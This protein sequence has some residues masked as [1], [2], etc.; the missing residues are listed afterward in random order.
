MFNNIIYLS[1][2]TCG[3]VR[4]PMTKASSWE[5]KTRK[6]TKQN[7]W[8]IAPGWGH[9]KKPIKVAWYVSRISEERKKKRLWKHNSLKKAEYNHV[10]QVTLIIKVVTTIKNWKRRVKIKWKK[11][12]IWTAK[13][14]MISWSS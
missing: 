9:R 14:T 13:M 4:W 5:E 12:T 8:V 11:S 1:N 3:F 10:L 6:E 7:T 2:I